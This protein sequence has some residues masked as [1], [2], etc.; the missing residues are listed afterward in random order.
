MFREQLM[1][2]GDAAVEREAPLVAERDREA[3]MNEALP[4]VGIVDDVP[5]RTFARD[6]RHHPVQPQP[7][8]GLLPI[9]RHGL[10]ARADIP[11]VRRQ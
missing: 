10:A 9:F 6:V 7:V 1:N 5:D 2:A 4:E 8:A 3:G 11:A